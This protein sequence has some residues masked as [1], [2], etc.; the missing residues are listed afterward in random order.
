MENQ[1]GNYRDSKG[2]GGGVRGTEVGMG[3]E[4]SQKVCLYPALEQFRGRT[5][6]EEGKVIPGGR[7]SSHTPSVTRS[8]H[9][10][11]EAITR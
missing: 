10:R 4:A 2:E 11:C 7:S 1:K 8:D 3:L 9:E 5:D 6:L